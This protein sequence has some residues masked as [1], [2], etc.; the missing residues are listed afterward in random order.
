MD[1]RRWIPIRYRDFWNVPRIFLAQ[2]G[3]QSYLFDC[4][5]DDATG[6]YPDIYKVYTIPTIPDESLPKDWDLLLPMVT[7]YQG[8]VPLDGV[9]FDPSRRRFIDAAILDRL[10]A[11][12][13]VV[14]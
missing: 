9:R 10:R 2:D 11:G 1:D 14:Q 12:R 13:P 5:F 4:K 8:E 7:N 6:D 3:T